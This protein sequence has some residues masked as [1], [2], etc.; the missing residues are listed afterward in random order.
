MGKKDR[1]RK[2]ESFV[3]AFEILQWVFMFLLKL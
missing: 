3:F 2:R 1:E